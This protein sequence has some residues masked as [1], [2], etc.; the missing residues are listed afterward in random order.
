VN[1]KRAYPPETVQRIALL[2]LAQVCGFSLDEI[3]RL[4][5]TDPQLIQLQTECGRRSCGHLTSTPPS[6]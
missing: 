2:K 1:G 5:K 3:R 4:H 6:A